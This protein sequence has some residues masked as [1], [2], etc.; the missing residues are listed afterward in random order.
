MSESLKQTSG[1]GAAGETEA[2]AETQG[3]WKEME[4]ACWV[5]L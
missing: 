4:T 1:G 5:P 2:A 3:E